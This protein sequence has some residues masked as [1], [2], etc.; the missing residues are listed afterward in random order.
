M[1]L[2]IPVLA[3]AVAAIPTQAPAALSILNQFNPSQASGL[4]GIAADEGTGDVWVYGCS[5]ANIQRYSGAGTF[6]VSIPRPGESAND[7][8]VEV[9]PV[10][11]TL[12]DTP[13]PAGAILFVNGESGF[14]EIYAVDGS[15]GAVLKTLV[16]SFGASH[17]VGGAYHPSRGTIFL[18]QDRVPGGVDGNRVA[19]IDPTTGS[20]LNS[21]QTT[22]YFDVNYGDLDVCVLSANLFLVSSVEARVAEVTPLGVLVGYH[23]LPAGVSSLSGIG[24]DSTTGLTW[25]GGTGGNAWLLGGLPCEAGS[26]APDAAPAV[27]SPSARPNPARGSITIGYSLLAES[28][29]RFDIHDPSGRRIHSWVDGLKP[30]G[31]HE[32]VWDGRDGT[33][34]RVSPGVYFYSL[35]AGSMEARGSVIILD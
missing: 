16:T 8:D 22:A 20:V 18:L 29:I 31:L 9:A 34:A 3:F 33:G 30:A 28:S 32:T 17:V 25:V 13:V 15:T 24:F 14:A 10:S 21:F 2:L 23:D 7:V 12:G 27:S 26:A 4:C 11:F 1:R 6:L 35:R 5:E 19:E